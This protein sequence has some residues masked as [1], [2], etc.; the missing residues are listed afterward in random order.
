MM[1]CGKKVWYE[2]V[3]FVC[4]TFG[5]TFLVIVFLMAIGSLM[6]VMTILFALLIDLYKSPWKLKNC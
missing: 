6:G 2:C 3:A 5:T 1:A 4:L